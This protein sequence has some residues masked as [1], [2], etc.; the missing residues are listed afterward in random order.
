MTDYVPEIIQFIKKLIESKQAYTVKS[1][2]VYFDTQKF[3]IKS[4]HDHVEADTEL[5][6]KG[7]I[8]LFYTIFIT[9]CTVP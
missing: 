5:D 3:N 8:S 2:S 4:F 9:M 6:S 1:G 7:K